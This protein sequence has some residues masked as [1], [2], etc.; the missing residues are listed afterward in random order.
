[1]GLSE[2]DRRRPHAELTGTGLSSKTNA[3]YRQAV[4]GAGYKSRRSP[5]QAAAVSTVTVE[6]PP[7]ISTWYASAA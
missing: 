7:L 1:V 6:A 3:C 4:T 2:E 5:L